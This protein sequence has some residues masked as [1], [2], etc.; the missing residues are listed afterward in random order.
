MSLIKIMPNSQQLLF[1][2]WAYQPAFN[3]MVDHPSPLNPVAAYS[4]PWHLNCSEKLVCLDS[5]ELVRD[6]SCECY[7]MLRSVSLS[8]R[9][10]AQVP[11]GAP[12]TVLE[13]GW[14]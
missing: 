2:S 7:G 3:L 13:S 12:F 9:W 6:L 14:E 5:S 4:R 8:R 1:P 10:A 11:T